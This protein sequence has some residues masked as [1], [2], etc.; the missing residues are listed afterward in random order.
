VFYRSVAHLAATELHFCCPEEKDSEQT[1]S[2]FCPNEVLHSKMKGLG[3]EAPAE[4]L[5][6]GVEQVFQTSN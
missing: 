3:S 5:Q 2:H 6:S 4:L 1:L